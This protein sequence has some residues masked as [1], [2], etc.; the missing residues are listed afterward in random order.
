[1]S[2][3]FRYLA[4]D[5]REVEIATTDE[6]VEAF[7]AGRIQKD[8]LLYDAYGGGWAPARSHSALLGVDLSDVA[9]TLAESPPEATEEVLAR[10][11]RERAGGLE[12]ASAREV[13]VPDEGHQGAP[14]SADR[15]G[16]EVSGPEPARR[17]EPPLDWAT[18]YPE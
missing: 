3:R 18:A 6:L 14:E 13:T 8:T 7:T 12:S 10:L 2:A 5:G 9:F 17:D 16:A 4:P 15:E 11:L 1:M